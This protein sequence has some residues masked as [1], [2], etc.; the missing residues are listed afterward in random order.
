[1]STCLLCVVKIHSDNQSAEN[2]FTS[3]LVSQTTETMSAVTEQQLTSVSN[4]S[5]AIGLYDHR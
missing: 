4:N 1:M 3:R 2:S 5:I